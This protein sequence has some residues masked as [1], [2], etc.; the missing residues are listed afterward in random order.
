MA[1]PRHRFVAIL[2]EHERGVG[3]RFVD[4]AAR[5]CVCDVE[6]REVRDV[7]D[8]VERWR[9]AGVGEVVE[10]GGDRWRTLALG[11]VSDGDKRWKPGGD[12]ELLRVGGRWDNSKKRWVGDAA[13]FRV[14][15]VHRGQEVAARWLAQW[16]RCKLTGRWD[17]FRRVYSTLFNGGRRSGKS[18][19]AVIALVLYAAAY[20][21][22]VCWAIS[23]TQEETDE[24]VEALRAQLPVEWYRWRGAGSGKV[25]SATLW[26]GARV[27]FLSGHK[28][29]GLKRGRVDLAVYNEAQNQ[30]R[31][32]FTQLRGAIA[33]KGGLVICT[34]NPPDE[35]IG[36]W[37][38]TLYNDAVASKVLV[39]VFDFKPKENPWIDYAALA[40]MAQE[41]DERTFAR[42]I[43][44]VFVPIGDVVFHAWSDANWIVPRPELVDVTARFTREKLGRA[45]GYVVGM[46]FQKSPH[47]AARV[48][49]F[50]TDPNDDEQTVIPILVDEF[51]PDD[52]SEDD[53]L[54]ALEGGSR[55][56]PAGRLVDDGYR[57]WVEPGDDPANPVHCAVVM[58][59]SAW[60]Q[61]GEH[62]KGKASDKRLRA[63]RWTFLYRPH[64]DEQGVERKKNPDVVE[65]VKLGNA[66]LKNA[67][68]RRRWFVARHCS[69]SANELRQYEN[70]HGIPYSRSPFSHGCDAATY[71]LFR[72]WGLPRSKKKKPPTYD[73][74]RMSTRADDLGP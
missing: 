60:W 50:F 65:R 3:E 55:W 25:S 57:G 52:A 21:G 40:A 2:L 43:D 13:A 12:E 9:P 17:D 7:V 14:L 16:F 6:L 54:D 72:F 18:H 58:D 24:L 59:A 56:T 28:S 22:A 62:A 46:D 29:R 33:D 69:T 32:G 15:R 31:K 66:M 71:V 26:N 20:P 36:R 23:P 8:G 41:N 45:F 11:E 1:T 19:L 49:K 73:R 42:E 74:V 53:L 37:V 64:V 38:E 30:H 4:I 10:P 67:G 47:M 70:R 68:G 51:T 63:R 61:D 48:F 5:L 44:G 27:M 34:C 35:P 39:G